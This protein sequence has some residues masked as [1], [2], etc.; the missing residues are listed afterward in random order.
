METKITVAELAE[1][2]S[3]VLDRVEKGESFVVEQD[4]EPLAV[5][6]AAHPRPGITLRELMA[7]IGNL[8]PVGGGFADDLEEIQASQPMAEDSK[9]DTE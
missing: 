4:G 6:R 2:L 8:M 9:W 3:S 7:Q 1:N 5:I